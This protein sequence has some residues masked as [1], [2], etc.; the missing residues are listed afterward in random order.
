MT[1]DDDITGMIIDVALGIHRKLGP[2][3]L[4]SA[5]EAVLARSL[6]LRGMQVVRQRLLP[7]EFEG[8]RFENA[9]RVDMLVENRI[10]V[11][12]KSTEKLHPVHT[13]QV[14]TYLR[15]LNFQVG[16]LINFGGETLR[17]GIRRVVN[18]YRAPGPPLQDS[19]APPRP[20][21]LRVNR[22]E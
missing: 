18:N 22:L 19:S 15:L 12:L 14:L 20:P 7:F 9:L 8:I 3:L 1:T 10:V 21:R 13:K 17:E 2:G 6:E 16:L 4:E 11:E 5:Y